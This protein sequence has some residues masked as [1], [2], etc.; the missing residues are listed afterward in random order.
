MRMEM[1]IEI[2]GDDMIKT[3]QYVNDIIEMI[4]KLSNIIAITTTFIRCRPL[5]FNTLQIY[6]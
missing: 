6:L 5:S 1:G 3:K 2:N 4:T